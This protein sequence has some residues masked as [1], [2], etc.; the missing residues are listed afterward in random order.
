MN[1]L[2]HLMNDEKHYITMD[3]YCKY[4]FNKKTYKISLNGNFSCP[5]RDG[6]LSYDGCIFC[7]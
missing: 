4:K 1:D 6:T 7:S 2:S 5:N 3:A